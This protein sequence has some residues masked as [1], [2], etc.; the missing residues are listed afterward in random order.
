MESSLDLM[1]GRPLEFLTAESCEYEFDLGPEITNQNKHLVEERIL[2]GTA[3]I[4]LKFCLIYVSKIR[5][6]I[7]N[8]CRFHI[9]GYGYGP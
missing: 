2:L 4:F 1:V 8:F 5:I 9:L 6:Q 3:K 7:D